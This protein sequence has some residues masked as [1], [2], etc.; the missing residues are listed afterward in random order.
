MNTI[1]G[2]YCASPIDALPYIRALPPTC[3]AKF[4]SN[5]IRFVCTHCRGRDDSCHARS[6]TWYGTHFL[7]EALGVMRG[8]PIP[9][10]ALRRATV[11]QLAN[12][13]ARFP[14]YF[15]PCA[16]EEWRNRCK[17]R[18]LPPVLCVGEAFKLVVAGVASAPVVVYAYPPQLSAQA[19]GVRQ[20]NEWL[21]SHRLHRR[22]APLVVSAL[23]RATPLPAELAWHVV[24]FVLRP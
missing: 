5:R 22:W 15:G 20:W 1:E 14:L 3:A 24:R 7:C 16:A 11:A 13:A 12:A 2:N 10:V 9:P 23:T 4:F 19:R 18:S 6:Q 17:A 21:I 8:A